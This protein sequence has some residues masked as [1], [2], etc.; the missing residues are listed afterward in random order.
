MT[1]GI[2][3]AML[4]KKNIRKTNNCQKDEIWLDL[5]VKMQLL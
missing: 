5:Y 2:I 3:T 1:K 4:F